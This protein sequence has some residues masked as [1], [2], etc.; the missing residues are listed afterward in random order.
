MKYF[1]YAA[2][3]PMDPDAMK[4]WIEASQRYFGNSSSLHDTGTDA[5]RLL[6]VSRQ[7]LAQ[8]LGVKKES[9]VFTSGG[10]ESNILALETFLTSR[11]PT[12]NHIIIS[13]T[14]HASLA[15]YVKKLAASGYEVTYLRHLEDGRIDVE[16]LCESLHERTCM[17]IVQHVN[18][19]TGVIQPIAEIGQL[20][21]ECG[22][23][24]HVDCVQSFAKFSLQ[25][26]CALC[27]SVSVSSHKVY[28]PKGVGAVIFPKISELTPPIPNMT[29][30]GGFRAGTVNVPGIAA[31]I[32]AANALVDQQ[33]Q[34][35]IR[36]NALR[37]LCLNQL[38]EHDMD[39]QAIESSFQS[40]YILALTCR[41]LQGQYIML[42]LNRMGFAISTGSACQIGKQDP[43]RTMI[44]RGKSEEEAHQLIRI[45]FGKRTTEEDVK[46]LCRCIIDIIT[47]S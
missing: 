21:Q 25:S 13:Q 18:S 40:P 47:V 35:F 7:Q 34:E 46:K 8:I 11:N 36:M 30:E 39:V 42:E 29:H 19:E 16:H 23:F 10:T 32:T 3:T 15:N 45:S 20:T 9:V 27:D 24:L 41:G 17:V 31:F 37:D 6:D 2:T 4:I 26:I 12:R 43:S 5:S 38:S 1:D 28:G 22:A 14:E 33:S 44:A